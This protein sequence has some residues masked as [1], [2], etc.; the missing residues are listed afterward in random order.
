MVSEENSCIV[1]FNGRLED[2][3]LLVKH[4]YVDS[5]HPWYANGAFKKFLSERGQAPLTNE[6]GRTV[7]HTR[8]LL[9]YVSN[10]FENLLFHEGECLLMGVAHI[11]EY[12][13][14][15]PIQLFQ[16]ITTREDWT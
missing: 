11:D 4:P 5:I 14:P 1:E 7:G 13:T 9:R 8:S 16:N 6:R 2:C 3:V 15:P 10:Y 12:T